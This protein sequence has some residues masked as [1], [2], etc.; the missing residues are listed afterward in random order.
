[1]LKLSFRAYRT[2]LKAEV[3]VRTE[4]APGGT[5]DSEHLLKRPVAVDL[6]CK[7]RYISLPTYVSTQSLSLRVHRTSRQLTDSSKNLMST[8]QT[9]NGVPAC[10]NSNLPMR[11]M[12]QLSS[13]MSI[14]AVRETPETSSFSLLNANAIRPKVHSPVM[15]RLNPIP[16]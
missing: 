4:N 3:L 10:I 5:A 12:W 1:M 14:K 16:R 13:T 6:V 11:R 15:L 7:V 9:K 8:C 2:S